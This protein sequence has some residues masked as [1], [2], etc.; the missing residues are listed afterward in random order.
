MTVTD[1]RYLLPTDVDVV[2]LPDAGEVLV[3]RRGSRIPPQ[4]L[5][6]DA[7]ALVGRFRQPSTLTEAILGYCAEVGADPV[8]TL[9]ESF[10]VLVALTG[11]DVLVAD[12]TDSAADLTDRHR[13]GDQVGPA[14]VRSRVRV[15]RDSEIWRGTLADGAP[16]I[17]KVIDQAEVGPGLL[18]REVAALRCLDRTGGPGLVWQEASP[19]GGVV[20]LT[21]VD[22]DPADLAALGA[23]DH[24]RRRIALTVL[25]AYADLLA[26]GVLHGDVHPGN[27]L[28]RADGRV[29]LIDFGLAR[30]HD[31]PEPPRA[32]GGEYLDP[33]AAT[34]L[35]A[36]DDPPVV[37]QSAEQYAVAALVFRLLTG[38]PYLDLEHERDQALRLI[39]ADPP[40]RFVTVAADAWPAGEQVLRRALAKQ[41]VQRFGSLA[42]LRDAFGAAIELSAAA[43]GEVDH[44]RDHDDLDAAVAALDVT[45]VIWA[46]AEPRAVAH[47]AWFLRRVAIL[48]GDVTAHDLAELWTCRSGHVE[49]ERPPRGLPVARA[50]RALVE[51]ARSGRGR[52]LREALAVAERL[53]GGADDPLDAAV[54][55]HTGRWAGIL[56]AVECRRPALAR[57]CGQVGGA[58]TR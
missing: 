27:V 55:V 32:A 38:A 54:D 10:G 43:G 47:A 23:D 28:V 22:G 11:T 14:T 25:D 40:R 34:A 9:E 37:D 2:L 21:E 53:R 17:I 30:V 4:L 16:V 45:G 1:Q 50:H 29:T 58:P 52:S 7:M 18:A 20:V 19:T 35:L 13:I 36:G 49:P 3:A 39:V 48:T 42:E 33:Q 15:L 12:G 56:L 24:E 46:A 41:P 8:A 26:H 44:G 6:A 51:Y 31:G 5:S 57:A